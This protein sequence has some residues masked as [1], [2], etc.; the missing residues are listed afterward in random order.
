M[1]GIIWFPYSEVRLGFSMLRHN[2][3]T[4]SSSSFYAITHPF[5]V[6]RTGDSYSLTATFLRM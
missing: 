6:I 2:M 5:A 1:Y 3:A 4:C